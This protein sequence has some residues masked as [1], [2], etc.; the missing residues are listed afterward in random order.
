MRRLIRLG[1]VL[2]LAGAA[3]LWG[4]SS[5]A[6]ERQIVISD[7]A[8]N[9]VTPVAVYNSQDEEYL[10]VWSNDRPGCDDIRAQRLAW[11]GTLL[12]GPFYISA[13]CPADRRDPDVAYDS[14]GNQYLVVWEHYDAGSGYS[15]KGRR[16][17]ASGQVL[18]PADI[19]IRGPG[20]PTYTP[21]GP[22]VDFAYTANRFLVVWSETWHPLPISYSVNAQ[23]M[24]GAGG[25]DGSM[26]AVSSFNVLQENVDLAY[27]RAINGY[28]VVWEYLPSKL[29]IEGRMVHG[30]GGVYGTFSF[31][32]GDAA[33][34]TTAP[35]VAAI[36]DP[37]SPTFL[38]VWAQGPAGSRGIHGAVVWGWSGWNIDS[39]ISPLSPLDPS[40]P[41]VAARESDRRH[42]VAWRHPLGPVDVPIM[43][44]FL[45]FDMG[46]VGLARTYGGTAA[47]H[48]T[49]A[50]GAGGLILVAWQD[51]PLGATNTNIYGYV[52]MGRPEIFSD[53][54]ESGDV[55]RWSSVAP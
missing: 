46:Y 27:N 48:P 9:E 8:E 51:Q 16:V 39:P 12:G 38:V 37:A 17:S 29:H 34:A 1:A 40:A 30:G 25:L 47:D 41:A 33:T 43:G 7:A 52:G 32:I 18:D 31:Q 44:R 13:G 20:A 49:V 53:G 55:S 45:S 26:F 23:V 36:P 15:I 28:L 10:A 5:A 50:A 6:L 14:I 22:A 35:R 21:R 24:T 4:S 3:T 11:D 2:V 42:Y 54:F 19:A